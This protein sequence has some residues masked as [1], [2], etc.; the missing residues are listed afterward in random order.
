MRKE[1][2]FINLDAG[3]IFEYNGRLWV[4]Q[5]S[6]STNRV[7]SFLDPNIFIVIPIDAKVIVKT[8]S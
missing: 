5:G 7:R 3:T 8:N 2:L 6:G 4:K 1:E